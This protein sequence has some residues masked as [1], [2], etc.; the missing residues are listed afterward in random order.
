MKNISNK[1]NKVT[2]ISNYFMIQLDLQLKI[3]SW[4][5]VMIFTKLNTSCITINKN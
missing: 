5:A 3:V 2:K 1:S 4:T